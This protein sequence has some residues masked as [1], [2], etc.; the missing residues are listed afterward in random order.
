MKSLQAITQPNPQNWLAT[1]A[2]L[3]GAFMN[4]LD[5]TI[6]NLALPA[7]RDDL[8][9]GP[10]I[11]NALGA[12][13]GPVDW[14]IFDI[15]RSLWFGMASC[16]PHQP[17]NRLAALVGAALWLPKDKVSRRGKADWLGAGCFALCI[18]LL[19][20][21]MIEGRSLGWP[22]WLISAPVAATIS[23]W[24]FGGVSVGWQLSIGFKLCRQY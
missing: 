23:L 15:R 16:L 11:N 1:G 17:A 7:I 14:R 18:S 12:V 22:V 21:P 19:I 4:M 10:N 24:P 8:G 9:A 20:Y 3:V 6:V 5:A 2:L 13:A